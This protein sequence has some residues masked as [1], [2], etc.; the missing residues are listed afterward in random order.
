MKLPESP[1]LPV[2]YLAAAFGKTT[3]SYKFFWLLAILEKMK[4]GVTKIN[5]D[6]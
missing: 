5:I 2:E 3:N 1:N 4:I 6:D